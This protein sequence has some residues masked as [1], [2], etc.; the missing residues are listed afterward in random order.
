MNGSIRIVVDT[1]VYYIFL[2]KPES[3]AGRIINHALENKIKIFSPDTVKE[4]M[5][6]LLIRDFK[7]KEDEKEIIIDSLPVEWVDKEVY[8]DQMEKACI[9]KHKQDRPIL[10]CA[11]VLG[12]GVLTA[13]IR[14]FKPA[15]KLVK[16]WDIDEL[17]KAIK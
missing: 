4:E 5:S 7:F 2:Y 13:N 8:K 17:L 14:H 6:R 9:I 10:A 16:I 11:L 15:R 3:K 1:N 12:C